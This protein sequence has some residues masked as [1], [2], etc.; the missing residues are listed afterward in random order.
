MKV[1]KQFPRIDIYKTGKN[2]KA[3]MLE[4]GMTV[5]KLQ[6]YLGLSAPQSIYH[7]FDGTSLPSVDN[8]YALSELFGVPM[9]SLVCGSRKVEFYSGKHRACRRLRTYYERC[10]QLKVG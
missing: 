10:N 4:R 8:L 5:K 6:K 2:I 7:W 3:L 9:D 1:K